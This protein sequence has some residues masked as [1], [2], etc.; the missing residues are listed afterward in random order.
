M[1]S[2]G[3]VFFCGKKTFFRA[4]V[5][6]KQQRKLC[7]ILGGAALVAREGMRSRHYDANG[8]DGGDKRKRRS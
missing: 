2:V 3:E 8:G 5:A 1:F 6:V 7:R 4:T